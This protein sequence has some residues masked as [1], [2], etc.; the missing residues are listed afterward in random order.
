M[1]IQQFDNMVK[2]GVHLVDLYQVTCPPCRKLAPVIEEVKEYYKDL[3]GIHAVNVSNNPEIASRYNIKAVPALLYFLDGQLQE[4]E[5]GYKSRDY[6]Q[7]K[8]NYYLP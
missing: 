4:I 8:L 2:K 6:L 1:T 5:F 7:G 3:A